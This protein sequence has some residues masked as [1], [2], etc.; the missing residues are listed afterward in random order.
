M[1]KDIYFSNLKD[2]ELFFNY[3]CSSNHPNSKKEILHPYE[4]IELELCDECVRL[5]DYAQDRLGECKLDPKP[6]CRTCS[7]RCYNKVEWKNM[8]KVMKYSGIRL[9]LI[10][11][12]NGSFLNKLFQK[13]PKI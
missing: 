3:Y 4:D 9:G 2:L 12:K 7:I 11:L 13:V 5:F 6:K 10:K 1:K 8:A